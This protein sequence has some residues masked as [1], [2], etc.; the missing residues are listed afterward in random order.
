MRSPSRTLV[1]EDQSG[2]GW[3][4]TYTPGQTRISRPLRARC[5]NAWSIA[6]LFPKCRRALGHS[7][8]PSG[9]SAAWVIIRRGRLGTGVV[10]RM[11][12]QKY[13][14]VPD[15]LQRGDRATSSREGDCH[16][17]SPPLMGR[18]LCRP[19]LKGTTSSNIA[20]AIEQNLRTGPWAKKLVTP[21]VIPTKSCSADS[22]LVSRTRPRRKGWITQGA[23]ASWVTGSKR[24][25]K[26]QT[27]IP[28]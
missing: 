10:S 27:G 7:S 4:H 19:R 3:G 24:D 8:V 1:A 15:N 14:I 20:R 22:G 16:F 23:A 21:R 25:R 5:D 18:R 9:D 28:G 6:A 12:C 17:L 11:E 2:S 26:D 13:S